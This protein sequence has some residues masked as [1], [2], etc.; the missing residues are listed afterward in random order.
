MSTIFRENLLKEK[1]ALVSGGGSGIGFAIAKELGGLGASVVICGRKVEKLE[2]AA[3]ELQDI[4]INVLSR[5]CDIR[6]VEQDEALVDFVLEKH[7]KIDILVNNAGG[8]FPSPAIAYSP[9]GW[10]AVINTNL[11]GTWYMTQTV[12]KKW[13]MEHGGKVI[14]IVACMWKGFPALAH[15]G[16]ARAAVVNL[17]KSLSVEWAQF[18]ILVNCVAPGI[19][20]SSGLS[21][22]SPDMIKD[23]WQRVPLKRLGTTEEIAWSVAYLASPAGDYYTGS[24]L[25]IDGGH[26]HW[27]DLWPIPD[28][29]DGGNAAGGQARETGRGS[30]GGVTRPGA[31]DPEPAG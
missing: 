8:Q 21:V 29:H 7:G 16:A 6:V 12:A 18:K 25:C 17:T 11:N 20:A 19:I 26:A 22:Y 10:N 14:N 27:G 1:V 30:P 4:G 28:P 13:M 9:K 15:T 3:L 2:K 31:A 5:Q 24:T 23:S